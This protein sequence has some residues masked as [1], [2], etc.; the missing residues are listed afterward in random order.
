MRPV[1]PGPKSRQ[2][3]TCMGNGRPPKRFHPASLHTV[4]DQRAML[5][6]SPAPGLQ[7]AELY[8]WLK[9]AFFSAHARTSATVCTTW[10]TAES[11]RLFGFTAA[12]LQL[13]HR[14]P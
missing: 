3:S 4:V 6:I 12:P 9:G 7:Q 11:N 13:M 14:L 2:A 5:P 10:S 1:T 8:I